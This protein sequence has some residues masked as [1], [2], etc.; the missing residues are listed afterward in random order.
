MRRLLL[1][2]WW[3][4]GVFYTVATLL[5]VDTVYFSGQRESRDAPISSS[6]PSATLFPAPPIFKPEKLGEV[7]GIAQLDSLVPYPS[8]ALAGTHAAG[9]DEKDSSE[10]LGSSVSEFET[11]GA[12]RLKVRSAA[13]IRSGPSSRAVIIGTA[14][15]GAELEVASREAGWVRFVDPATSNTGWIHEGLLDPL[16]ADSVPPTAE[17]SVTASADEPAKPKVKGHTRKVP[18]PVASRRAPKQQFVVRP[19][20]SGNAELPSDEEFGPRKRG[21]GFFGRRRIVQQGFLSQ[22]HGVQ[23]YE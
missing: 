22:R 3:I 5:L 12:E 8:L 7:A 19:S 23:G 6:I 2:L 15:A 16:I 11:E 14:Q 9:D 4:G 17:K 1:C 20:L 21:A 18:R 13:K 10:R